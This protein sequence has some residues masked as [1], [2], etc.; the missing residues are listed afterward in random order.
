MSIEQKESFYKIGIGKIVGI[1]VVIAGLAGA[2]Q[3]IDYKVDK[4]AANP[5]IIEK[6]R[7]QVRPT[8][9]FDEKGSIL[10]DMGARQYIEDDIKTK[11]AKTKDGYFTKEIRVILKNPLSIPILTCLDN[12]VDYTVNPDRGKNLEILYNLNVNSYSKPRAKLS[13][14]HLEVIS[15]EALQYQTTEIKAKR[16][17]YFPG[18]IEADGIISR[19][20]K[21]ARRLQCAMFEDPK[22]K[23]MEGD[24]YYNLRIKS[25]VTYSNGKWRELLMKGDNY[26]E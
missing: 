7:Q 18:T 3:Y 15:G 13:L 1:L 5:E 11:L 23:P 8:L 6:I 14:F 20:K 21:G 12:T 25:W 4:A 10:S 16:A 9:I 22:Y 19:Y 17:M 2:D 24:M 26:K